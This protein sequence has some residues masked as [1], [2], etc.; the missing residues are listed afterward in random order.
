MAATTMTTDSASLDAL[1]KE[2][3]QAWAKE[4]RDA[5]HAEGRRAAGG[6]PG[7]R[8]E[9]R[10]RAARFFAD[11]SPTE[12]D[13]L[14]TLLYHSARDCWLDAREPDGDDEDDF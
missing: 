4:E 8:S 5:L 2:L 12:R 7:V 1:A 9:A 13:R 14:A 10:N 6:W 3:G 11:Q